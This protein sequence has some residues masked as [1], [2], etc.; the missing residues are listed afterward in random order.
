MVAD[1]LN[2]QAVV[3]L[4]PFTTISASSRSVI[5]LIGEI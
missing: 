4:A 1:D 3:L 2:L 5:F